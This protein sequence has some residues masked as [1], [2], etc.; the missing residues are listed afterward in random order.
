MTEPLDAAQLAAIGWHDR[1]GLGDSANQFHYFRLSSDNRILWGGYDAIY[2]YGGKMRA[3]LDQRPETFDRLADHFFAC[4]P[5]LEGVRFTHAW[6]GAI[7]TCSRFSAFFG[8]AHGGASRTRPATRGSGS[9]P[10]ASAP[11]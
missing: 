3:A 7:D 5:Q 1:Q 11:T 6:G 9:G 8:T 10:P 2:P 4:F